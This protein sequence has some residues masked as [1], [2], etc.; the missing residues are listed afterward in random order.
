[1]AYL[2]TT[3]LLDWQSKFA[4]NEKR[5]QEFGVIDAVKESGRFQ[6]FIDPETMA[7]M[8]TMSGARDAQI[9]VMKD[10]TVTVT[11][12]PSF[13]IPANLEETD[14]YAFSAIDIVSGFRHYPATY[15][16]NAERGKW[17]AAEKTKNVLMAMASAKETALLTVMDTRKT[18]LLSGTAQVSDTAGDYVFNAGTD[19]LEIKLAAQKETMFYKLKELMG[20]NK[21]VGDGRI[22]T[23]PAGLATQKSEALKY[24]ASN[25]KNI[26]AL[27]FV[28]MDRLHE[29]FAISSSVKFDGYWLRDGSIGFVNNFPYNFQAGTS[30]AD[31]R[32]YISPMEMPFLRSRVNIYTNAAATDATALVPNDTNAIMTTFE[33]ILFW[34]RFYVIYRYNSNLA[35]RANDIVKIQGLTA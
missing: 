19:T 14:Q 25:E 32:W 16:N 7:A 9:P 17:A 30:L 11:S 12:S 13:I 18:Q 26:Q 23:N 4:T 3:W 34:D 15:G 10:Q 28:G 6:D 5:M 20:A 24:G 21:L 31:K 8:A 29:S 1:M 22:V 35:T 27:G 33:E 2:D